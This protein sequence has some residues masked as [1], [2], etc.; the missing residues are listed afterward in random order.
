MQSGLRPFFFLSKRVTKLFNKVGVPF[1]PLGIP[2]IF[3]IF[4]WAFYLAF[5]SKMFYVMGRRLSP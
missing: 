3:L 1:F 4:P 2:T 5:P